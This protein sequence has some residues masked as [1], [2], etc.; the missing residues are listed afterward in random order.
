MRIVALLLLG[1]CAAASAAAQEPLYNAAELN[2]LSHM[3][4]HHGQALELSALVPSRTDR[5]E[6][7]R[8]A[9]YIDGEQRAEIEHMQGMLKLAEE[10]G[11]EI[12]HHHMHG[13]PP[14]A[15]MLSKAQMAA[16]EKARGAE[17]ERLWLEGMMLHH[18]G[19]LDMGL[20]EQK[21]Q[22]ETGRR[23]YGLDVLTEDIVVVQRAEI[24]QMQ[25][26]LK[27]WKSPQ[28][29]GGSDQKKKR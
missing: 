28:S 7:K 16:L 29:P 3:I 2:F 8:F 24:T 22:F 14:M 4:G 12:P 27:E 25:T 11:I 23:P 13:D 21:R 9:R 26:W 17:F 5:E 1:L 15:G 6:L 19:A 20:E 18:Q 10:R